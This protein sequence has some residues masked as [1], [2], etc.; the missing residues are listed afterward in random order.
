MP[1][2]NS[3][4]ACLFL[5]CHESSAAEGLPYESVN[6]LAKFR[7]TNRW[8]KCFMIGNEI[9]Q[10]LSFIGKQLCRRP[11]SSPFGGCPKKVGKISIFSRHWPTLTWLSHTGTFL[12][13]W[14]LILFSTFFWKCTHYRMNHS[15]VLTHLYF[16]IELLNHAKLCWIGIFL[17]IFAIHLMRL[18]SRKV[19]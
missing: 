3:I 14:I 2:A 17:S 8:K 13:V 7:T 18:Y 10:A 9:S 15:C 12:L 6:C 1:L 11:W 4:Y 5:I 16:L 19:L